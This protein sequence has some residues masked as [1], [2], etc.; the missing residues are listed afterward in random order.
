ML[1]VENEVSLA[2]PCFEGEIG[3]YVD[4]NSVPE[5]E[6]EGAPQL[7]REANGEVW[8]GDLGKGLLS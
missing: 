1:T 4:E 3:E 7:N 6:G 8:L 2:L 5:G